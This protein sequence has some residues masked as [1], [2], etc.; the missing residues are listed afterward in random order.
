DIEDVN[1]R[2]EGENFSTKISPHQVQRRKAAGLLE[3]EP[4]G[5]VYNLF[6]FPS[7]CNFSGLRFDLDLAKVIKED[8]S[9]IL[10]TSV[11]K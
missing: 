3:G 5:D 2:I 1:P 8:P 6:A 7:E 4:M 10:G 11:C 9:R